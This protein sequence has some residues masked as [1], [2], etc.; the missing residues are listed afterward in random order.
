MKTALCSKIQQQSI[1]RTLSN[2]DAVLSAH[3]HEEEHP[4]FYCYVCQLPFCVRIMK[5]GGTANSKMDRKIAKTT[6]VL[7]AA[8]KT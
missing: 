5:W 4:F 6:A 2:Q 8:L 1:L 7:K 3:E